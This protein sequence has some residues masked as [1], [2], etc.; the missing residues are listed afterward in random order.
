MPRWL[1][2]HELGEQGRAACCVLRARCVRGG[3]ATIAGWASDMLMPVGEHA[4]T[5]RASMWLAWRVY[6]PYCFTSLFAVLTTKEYMR[7]TSEI[8]PE[9]LVSAA[10]EMLAI[11]QGIRLMFWVSRTAC[12][13]LPPPLR[14]T[15]RV[16][17]NPGVW[18]LQVEIAPHYYSKK[19]I[20]EQAQKK[21]PKTLG[22]AES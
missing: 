14:A 3:R 10:S 15:Y 5:T 9:W 1:V 21:L 11:L 7:I 16:L 12:F 22:K 13:E 18:A 8:K 6:Q 19:E 4:S 2:Y 17:F 20:M